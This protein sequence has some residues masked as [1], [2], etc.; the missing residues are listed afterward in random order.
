MA[1]TM[2]PSERPSYPVAMRTPISPIGGRPKR[3]TITS[4]TAAKA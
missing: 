1:E 3:P 2:I 4:A